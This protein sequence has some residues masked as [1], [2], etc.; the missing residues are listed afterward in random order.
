MR[1]CQALTRDCRAINKHQ[2]ARAQSPHYPTLASYSPLERGEMSLLLS[3]EDGARLPVH[4]SVEALALAAK[5]SL[6]VLA[7]FKYSNQDKPRGRSFSSGVIFEIGY[8][9]EGPSPSPSP[10]LPWGGGEELVMATLTRT[11]SS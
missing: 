10:S 5:A 6:R 4:C 2:E 9:G 3:M 1:V 8:Q 7:Q 11:F